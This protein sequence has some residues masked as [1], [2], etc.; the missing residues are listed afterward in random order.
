MVEYSYEVEANNETDAEKQGWEYEDYPH[1]AT[2]D[3]IE[4]SELE[5]EDDEDDDDE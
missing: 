1:S 5:E 2:V 3:S 4:V